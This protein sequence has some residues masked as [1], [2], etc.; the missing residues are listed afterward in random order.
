MTR[1]SETKAMMKKHDG[2]YVAAS[3]V[4]C[5]RAREIIT[6]DALYTCKYI[7]TFFWSGRTV[8]VPVA[9]HEDVHH[10]SRRSL[11]LPKRR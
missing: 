7:S 11:D 9:P 2:N 8:V 10:P 3:A 5:K 4:F 1:A 6:N